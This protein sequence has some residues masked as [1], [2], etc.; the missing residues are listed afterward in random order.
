MPMIFVS[1]EARKKNDKF[2][3]KFKGLGMEVTPIMRGLI[4]LFVLGVIGSM[5]EVVLP[6]SKELMTPFVAGYLVFAMGDTALSTVYNI[7]YHLPKPESES[8]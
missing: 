4:G 8:K 5:A 7:G 1:E 6:G 2:F 3:H